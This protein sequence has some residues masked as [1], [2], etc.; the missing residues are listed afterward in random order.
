M[1]KILV[2]D[3]DSS[4]RSTIVKYCRYE[5]FEVMEAANGLE[6]VEICCFNTFDVIIMDVM[7]P[8]IDGFSASSQIMEK[9]NTPIIMLSALGEEYDKL[10]GFGAGVI[11]YIVKPFSYKELIMRI[12]AISKFA[13]GNKEWIEIGGLKIDFSAQSVQIDGE[14]IRLSHKEAALLF[15]MAKNAGIALT[16]EKI[17]CNIWG[18]DYTGDERTLDAHIKILRKS[19]GEYNRCI[20]TIK[21]VGYRFDAKQ[22]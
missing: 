5:G 19:L 6:A 14:E 13:I 10:R 9:Y 11:D 21:G 18:Y 7:M 3:D 17:I 2:A 12:K 1:L 16:R 4:I 8:K 22:T 20:T 15:Y